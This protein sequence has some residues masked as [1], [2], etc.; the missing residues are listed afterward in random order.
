M[1]LFNINL[2]LFKKIK[3]LKSALG[4][5]ESIREGE[6]KHRLILRRLTKW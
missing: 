2:E 1:T 6:N 3:P 4:V 5:M